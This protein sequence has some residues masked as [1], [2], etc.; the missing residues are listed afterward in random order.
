[1]PHLFRRDI[2]GGKQDEG[3]VYA[4]ASVYGKQFFLKWQSEELPLLNT[5]SDSAD[6]VDKEQMWSLVG[7]KFL[8][9]GKHMFY[10]L[11]NH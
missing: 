8:K 2:V 1:M 7:R 3:F 5:C 10:F 9:C 6:D 4:A 11:K